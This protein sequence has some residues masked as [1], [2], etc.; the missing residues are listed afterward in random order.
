MHTA[1]I[2]TMLY[3]LVSSF[4]ALRSCGGNTNLGDGS[5]CSNS[6]LI[7]IMLPNALDGSRLIRKGVLFFLIMEKTLSSVAFE[8]GIVRANLASCMLAR[9]ILFSG[10]LN[11]IN[12]DG[13]SKEEVSFTSLQGRQ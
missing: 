4:A 1:L 5:H 6:I 2:V 7:V 8:G 3:F 9:S 12:F 13:K 11:T 10:S